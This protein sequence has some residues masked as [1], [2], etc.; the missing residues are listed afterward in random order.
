MPNSIISYGSIMTIVKDWFGLIAVLV[1][2][3]TFVGFSVS[4]PWPARAQVERIT[5]DLQNV[6]TQV[7]QQN[8][9]V[10]RV[11]LKSYESDLETAEQELEDNPNSVTAKNNK[12]ELL[13]TIADI[14]EQIK[15]TCSL[16]INNNQ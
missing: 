4:A 1:G 5:A 3:L 8:C 2:A 9:L 16:I 7:K 6:Q 10:L 11:L 12:R 13:Q 14:K 15:A